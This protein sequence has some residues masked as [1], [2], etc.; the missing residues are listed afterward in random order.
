MSRNRLLLI[1]LAALLCPGYS[2]AQAWTGIIDPARATDWTH[3]G[4]AGGIPSGSWTQCGSTIAAYSG[5]TD[6]INKALSACGAN[7]YVLLG[8]GTFN[9]AAGGA[10]SGGI[11]INKNNV[12]LRG[13]GANSTF[14]VMAPGAWDSC[15]GGYHAAICINGSLGAYWV[16][17][18]A[19]AWTAGFARGSTVITLASVAGITPNST[20]IALDQCS[21]GNSGAS[22]TANPEVDN[23]NFF[24]CDVAYSSGNGCAVN[25]PDGGNQ[26]TNRPQTEIFQV[27]AVNSST[28]Q[29]T[30][31]GSIRSP[32]WNPAQTPMATIGQ[33]VQHVGIENMSIDSSVEAATAGVALYYTAQSWVH[34]VR[35]IQPGYSGVWIIMGVHD[36]VEQNYIYSTS[37]LG[38][39]ADIFSTNAAP[40]SDNLFQANICQYDQVCYGNE[41]GDTGTVVAYNFYINDYNGNDGIY[42]AVFP[43]AGDRWQLYEGNIFNSYYGE[44]YHGP[45]LMSTHFRNFYTGWE[46]CANGA[47]CGTSTAKASATTSFRMVAYSRY[48]N[49]VANVFGTPGYHNS[50]STTAA[51]SSQNIYE[52][53]S[54]NGSIPTDSVV[55]TTLFRWANY[56]V[57]TG[58]ARFCGSASDTGWSS[59]CGS[60]SEVPTSIAF[61]PNPVPTKGDTGAGQGA[62]P[63]SFYLTSKPSWFGSLPFPAIGPDVAGGNVG[64]CSGTLN[65]P[66]HYSGVAATSSAQ[67]AGTSLTS[68]SWG[69]HVNANPAMNCYLNVMGGVPDGTGS[70]LT[71]NAS[72]CYGSL[73][74]APA[75][76]SPASSL[77]GT[78][79]E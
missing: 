59:T 23:G 7:Q 45:K 49:V 64:M 51:F 9:L 35:I 41:G 6:T 53:G 3:A 24:N 69:G 11:V 54:G 5:T 43:H 17:D 38:S 28:N 18:P 15:S 67:C 20:L 42:P 74:N 63:P 52:I 19:V 12:V 77:S 34:G 65:T 37:H 76:P 79:H 40:S 66:G 57:V 4:V 30:L 70:V 68:S 46:S 1:F 27:S 75:G 39:G 21:D 62:L 48:H 29:V 32:D 78:G 25:G 14:L 36:T 33:V 60:T 16:T 56:D 55:G 10:V 73:P 72:S 2:H 13:S 22:C 61:Y 31:I 58:T 26:R 8:P 44:N 50:Y 71:F 47:V